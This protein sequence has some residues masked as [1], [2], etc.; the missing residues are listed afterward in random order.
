MLAWARVVDRSGRKF[1]NLAISCLLG[2]LGLVAAIIVGGSLFAS[3]V[4]LTAA[5]IGVT[6]ACA[7]FWTIPTR[8]LTGV[9]A[10]GGLA[11]ISTIGTIGGF[12]GPA[13]M[14]W[15]KDLTG[16][17]MMGIA[18]MAAIMLA[19][20]VLSASLSLVVSRNAVH[21]SGLCLYHNK[22]KRCA[23]SGLAFAARL[24]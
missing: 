13:M 4:A 8:F 15:L 20:T 19:A 10:A 12:A 24:N 18:A 23:F 16:S 5:L 1:V 22:L 14:G 21:S 9:A 7:I 17:F 11:F 2:V 6:A 3:L